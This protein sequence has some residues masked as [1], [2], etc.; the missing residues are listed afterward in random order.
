MQGSRCRR[1]ESCTVPDIHVWRF[2]MTIALPDQVTVQFYPLDTMG[3]H[4]CSSAKV[5]QLGTLAAATSEDIWSTGCIEHGRRAKQNGRAPVRSSVKC[6]HRKTFDRRSI[7]H[8]CARH[9]T[10]ARYSGYTGYNM[11]DYIRLR[12]SIRP[13]SNAYA[14]SPNAST[15]ASFTTSHPHSHSASETELA[16]ATSHAISGNLDN[17]SPGS[18]LSDVSKHVDVACIFNAVI[19]ALENDLTTTNAR[20]VGQVARSVQAL[21][22]GLRQA[23][24]AAAAAADITK[25]RMKVRIVWWSTLV[26]AAAP[27]GSG[28][29]PSIHSR[30]IYPNLLEQER[31]LLVP[32][33]KKE[34][35]GATDSR[36]SRSRANGELKCDGI[37]GASVAALQGPDQVDS[38]AQVAQDV[39]DEEAPGLGSYQELPLSRRKFG[40]KYTSP[41]PGVGDTRCFDSGHSPYG[42]RGSDLGRGPT[43]VR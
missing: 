2:T 23:A 24:V 42:G 41:V 11:Q 28:K 7:V 13:M 30:S 37:Q 4:I 9:S 38:T 6:P 39:A 40:T 25:A 34:G 17:E 43:L 10:R 21:Y 15:F 16:W 14:V 26:A 22:R 1:G 5:A 32:P 18:T 36:L 35:V 19:E 31:R 3:S 8:D 12:I 20:F 29:T 33:R 27:E